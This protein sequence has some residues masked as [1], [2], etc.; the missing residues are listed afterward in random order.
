M[1]VTEDHVKEL[2]GSNELIKK[3][4]NIDRDSIPFDRQKEIFNKLVEEKFY[5]SQNS[6]ENINP[7]NLVCDF[8]TEGISPKHFSNDKI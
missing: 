6:K 4:F 3:D 1:K 5:E 2:A 8:K 7:N